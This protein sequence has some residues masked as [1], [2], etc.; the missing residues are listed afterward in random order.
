MMKIAPLL[1][2][3]MCLQCEYNVA[4]LLI[5]NEHVYAIDNYVNHCKLFKTN[6]NTS[7]SNAHS[8]VG[9]VFVRWLYS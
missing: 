8:R 9:K 6:D 4:L 7:V 3:D 2:L 1:L 5:N